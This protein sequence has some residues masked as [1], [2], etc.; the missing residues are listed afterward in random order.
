MAGYVGDWTC[1]IMDQQQDA[2][3]CLCPSSEHQH[4]TAA[5]VPCASVRV[6]ERARNALPGVWQAAG[7]RR[8]AAGI[9]QRRVAGGVKR[10]AGCMR[11]S[12]ALAPS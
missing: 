10:G 1:R 6:C 12:R 2:V 4:E 11:P 9:G 7:G 3:G 8:L 5:A